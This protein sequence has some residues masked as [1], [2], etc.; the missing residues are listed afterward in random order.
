M[1]FFISPWPYRIIRLCLAIIFIYAGTA[2]LI[3]PK[4]F[5]RTISSYD[6]LPG[7]LLP[8]VAIGLPILEVLA[9]IGLFLDLKGSLT[10]I[11]GLLLM[12][13]FVL[14]YGISHDLE[15][16]CGCFG[17][18]EIAA[19]DGLRTAFIRD[20][21]FIPTVVFL[22]GSRWIRKRSAVYENNSITQNLIR[23]E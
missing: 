11:T 1:P 10:V 12:F 14:G 16:D 3:D 23:E 21:I 17:A 2:K 7:S 9:G 6:L 20:L 13:F 15:G 19:K 5:A 22:Y 18:A 8:F 4:A